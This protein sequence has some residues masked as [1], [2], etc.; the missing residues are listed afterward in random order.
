MGKSKPK[1]PL[2]GDCIYWETEFKECMYSEKE[3]DKKC[4]EI[5][6]KKAKGGR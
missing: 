6:E 4:P 2:K 5:P 1:C 3:R